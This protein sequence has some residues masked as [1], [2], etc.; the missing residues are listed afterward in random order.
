VKGRKILDSILV[1]SEYLDSRIKSGVPRVLCK[2]DI[3]KAYDHINW[4]FLLYMLRMCGFG[5][6]W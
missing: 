6:K 4:E 1:A 3:E 2:L 5:E